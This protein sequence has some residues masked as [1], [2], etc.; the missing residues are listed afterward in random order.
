MFLS[1]VL[2]IS[3][4]SSEYS[5][6]EG[7]GTPNSAIILNFLPNQNPFILLLTPVTVTEVEFRSLGD[8]INSQSITSTYRTESTSN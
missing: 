3:F 6:A 8:F 4:G 2:E 1:A 5:M 7:S